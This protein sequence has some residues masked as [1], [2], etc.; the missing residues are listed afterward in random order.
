MRRDCGAPINA[1][2]AGSWFADASRTLANVVYRDAPQIAPS[3]L[4][5]SACSISALTSKKFACSLDQSVFRYCLSRPGAPLAAHSTARPAIDRQQL[6][7]E[8]RRQQLQFFKWCPRPSRL[9]NPRIG[10]RFQRPQRVQISY[11]T[12][13]ISIGPTRTPAI[14]SIRFMSSWAMIP[15]MTPRLIL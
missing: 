7:H 15:S 8:K 5:G 14:A 11:P 1:L 6:R 13:P 4:I 3:S 2:V 9:R 10:Y 12:R